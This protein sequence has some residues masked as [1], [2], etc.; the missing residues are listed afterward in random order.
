VDLDLFAA[1]S[2]KTPPEELANLGSTLTGVRDRIAAAPDRIDP[3]T[4]KPLPAQ[5]IILSST[6]P[7]TLMLTEVP[8]E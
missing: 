4:L 3:R 8:H 1:V 6:V 2:E 5:L 7:T